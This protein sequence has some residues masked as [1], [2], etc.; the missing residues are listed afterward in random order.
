VFRIAPF[1]EGHISAIAE[2]VG[3]IVD[4]GVGRWYAAS[5][6]GAGAPQPSRVINTTF[7]GLSQI[8]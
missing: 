6:I 7:E 1:G 3:L 4:R 8:V 2:A 5:S